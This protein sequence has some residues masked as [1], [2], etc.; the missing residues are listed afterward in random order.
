MEKK[1]ILST[2]VSVTMER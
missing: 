2:Y 1:R